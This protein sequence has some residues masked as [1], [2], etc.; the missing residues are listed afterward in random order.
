MRKI[1]LVM[2]MACIFILSACSKEEVTLEDKFEQFHFNSDSGVFT[3]SRGTEMVVDDLGK[4]EDSFEPRVVL[5]LWVG[6]TEPAEK[7]YAWCQMTVEERKAD[8]KECGD[9]VIEFAK[10]EEWDN[11]YYLYINV[12]TTNSD[13]NYVYD[14]EDDTLYVPND[15]LVYMQMYEQFGTVSKRDVAELDGGVDF[16]VNNDLAY[17]KHN[18]IE[19]NTVIGG[20][21]YIYEGEFHISLDDDD[22]TIY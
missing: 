2:M 12:Q 5:S 21:V 1:F 10:N 9:M 3:T 14:Y 7:A 18:E 11:D 13:Y 4:E 17:I 22:Y 19:Y 20:E 15:E 16:L 6:N 8:L